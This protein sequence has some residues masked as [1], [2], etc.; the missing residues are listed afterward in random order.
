MTKTKSKFYFLLLLTCFCGLSY[1]SPTWSANEYEVYAAARNSNLRWTSVGYSETGK[2]I[3]KR[4]TGNLKCPAGCA[5]HY[6]RLSDVINHLTAKHSNFL[7][8][9]PDWRP[10][11]IK[12]K[13]QK[14][15]R[16]F[17]RKNTHDIHYRNDHPPAE[18]PANEP[19]FSKKPTCDTPPTSLMPPTKIKNG[20]YAIDFITN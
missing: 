9:N 11:T 6:S 16:G 12:Y 8:D 14:C 5:K 2:S 3:S 7:N 18:K 4:S 1:F 15:G 10:A 17:T 20:Q 19:W 13:C